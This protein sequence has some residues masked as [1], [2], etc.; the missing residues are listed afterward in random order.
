[1]NGEAGD[2]L[3][4]LDTHRRSLLVVASCTGTA[5]DTTYPPTTVL[6]TTAPPTTIPPTTPTTEEDPVLIEADL[7]DFQPRSVV[8]ANIELEITDVKVSNQELRSY[9]DGTDPVV[10]DATY[11]FLDIVASNLT[12][13]SQIGLG[14]DVFRL[15]VD[16]TETVPD[17]SMSFLS[18]VGSLIAANTTV[19]S[20]LAGPVAEDVDLA[21][22]VLVVGALPDRIEELPLTGPLPVADYPVT[23]E[24]E[25]TAEGIGPTNA[26]TVVFSLLAATLA[27]DRPH[28]DA[29]S[30]T[31]E[32]AD[33]GELFLVLHV[34]AEK[35]SGRGLEL[36]SDAFRLLVD[37][38]PRAPW[39]VADDPGGSP[40][41][42]RVAPGAAVDA[43]VAFLVPDDAGELMLQVGDFEEDPG[44]ILLDITP[45]P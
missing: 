23:V 3:D 40:G 11:A 26:G 7:V 6:P 25:G 16:G 14:D 18:D 32:R 27:E 38:V 42:P 15:V 29:T 13:R 19:N 31:G 20:F 24:L 33:V 35:T 43:W 39:D 36:L 45:L 2:V 9:A 22:A 5:T 10:S 1:M 12:T 21:N 17:D 44:L 34:R 30:P 8:I 28:A 4:S 41:V 37:G